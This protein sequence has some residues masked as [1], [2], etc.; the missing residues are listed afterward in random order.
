MERGS[1]W[2]RK[3][4]THFCFLQDYILHGEQYLGSQMFACP[5]HLGIL[6]KHQLLHYILT[7]S[8][9]VDW[10]WGPRV[11]M[12]NIPGDANAAGLGPHFE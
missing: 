2:H 12:S 11:C 3:L 10:G 8:D 7:A 1:I 9:A 5:D 6:L 4:K